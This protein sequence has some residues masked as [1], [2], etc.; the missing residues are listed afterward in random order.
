MNRTEKTMV[1]PTKLMIRNCIEIP[2]LKRNTE[3]WCHIKKRQ[4]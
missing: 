4:K 3:M 1:D 2:K